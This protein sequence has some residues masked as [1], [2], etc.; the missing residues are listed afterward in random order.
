[1]LGLLHVIIAVLVLSGGDNSAV[2]LVTWEG[3]TEE[4]EYN[5]LTNSNFE[6]KLE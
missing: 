1:V 6:L 5:T 2:T 4:R 3:A